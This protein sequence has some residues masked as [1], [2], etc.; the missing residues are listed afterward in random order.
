M[1]QTEQLS[2]DTIIFHVQGPFHQST[3]KELGLSVFRSYH[4]GF[5]T[6]FFDL[7]QVPLIDEQG[8][9]HLALIGQGVQDKGG[10]WEILGNPPLLENQLLSHATFEN[11]PQETWN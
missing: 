7:S 9:R 11:P 5:T 10:K 4:L 3:A 8:S 2:P 1:I 6:F